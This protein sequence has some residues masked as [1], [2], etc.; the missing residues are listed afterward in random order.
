MPAYMNLEKKMAQETVRGKPFPWAE[1]QISC[2]RAYLAGT[3][4]WVQSQTL[5]KMGLVEHTCNPTTQEVGMD[6]LSYT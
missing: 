2:G 3:K 4:A 1:M 6:D 5:H